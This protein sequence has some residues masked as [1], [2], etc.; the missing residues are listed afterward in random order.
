M[1]VNLWNSKSLSIDL[2]NNVFSNTSQTNTRL[3]LF[4]K[5]ESLQHL[6]R[7]RIEAHQMAIFRDQ[8]MMVKWR[9]LTV[10]CVKSD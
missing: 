3:S 10:G 7:K 5:T 9:H 4:H 1:L 8:Q 6:H 2:E